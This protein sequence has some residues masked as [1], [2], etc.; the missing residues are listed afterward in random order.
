M[1]S[2]TRSTC[3]KLIFSYFCFSTFE[4][5]QL[6]HFSTD[7]CHSTFKMKRR[8]WASKFGIMVVKFSFKKKLFKILMKKFEEFWKNFEIYTIFEFS[9]NWLG[10]SYCEYQ[11]LFSYILAMLWS[12]QKKKFLAELIHFECR[13]IFSLFLSITPKISKISKKS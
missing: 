12:K 2:G 4:M 1:Q 6:L 5:Y 10:S 11:V 7:F 3:L 8:Y 9:H 13:P